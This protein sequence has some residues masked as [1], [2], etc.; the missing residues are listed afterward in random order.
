MNRRIIILVIL[1]LG[2]ITSQAQFKVVDDEDGL[3]LPGAYV[4]NSNNKLLGMT[5]ANGMTG[6]YSGKVKV[7]MMSYQPVTIDADTCHGEVRLVPSPY[8]LPDVSVSND[9]YIKLS[10][11][12]R[13]IVINDDSLVMYREGLVDFYINVKSTDVTRRIRACRQYEKPLLRKMLLKK[14]MVDDGNTI[15]L[16]RFRKIDVDSVSENRG[17]TVVFAAKFRKRDSKDG[18]LMLQRDSVRRVIIDNTQFQKLNFKLFGLS[19]KILQSYSDFT[20]KG[21]NSG[22]SSMISFR[23]SSIKEF[24]YSKNSTPIGIDEIKEFVVTSVESIDKAT[25]KKEMKDKEISKEFVLP[26]VFNN[27]TDFKSDAEENLIIR[28]FKEM[29]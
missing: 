2:V 12:L 27:Y 6:K 11:A 16:G 14:Y 8:S 17:D 10:G 18:I 5:D 23:K 4:F 28:D 3:P 15:H 24:Q 29:L 1:L 13:D 21:D 19:I 22:W 20:Y 26:D 9:E 25:A 7:S